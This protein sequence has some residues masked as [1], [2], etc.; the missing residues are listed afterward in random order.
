M[1][2]TWNHGDPY[3]RYVGRR[4]RR[5]APLFLA[6][7]DLP[8]GCRWLDVGCGTGALCAVIADHCSPS[9]VV[10]VESSEGS[11]RTARENLGSRAVLRQGD[12]ARIPLTDEAVDVAVSGPAL[13]F[14]SDPHAALAGA[15]LTGVD[16]GAI[17]IS[18]PFAGFE[19]SWQPFLGGQGAPPRTSCRS[20]RPRGLACAIESGTASRRRRT[21][22]SR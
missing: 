6:W 5:V 8:A 7:L 15:G 17:D 2:D 19:E 22:R 4:S 12:A 11:L 16:V 10:G 9:S 20:T 1:S 14:L 18:T 21:D 13:N 3:E